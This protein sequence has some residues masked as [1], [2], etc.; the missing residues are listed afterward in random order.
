MGGRVTLV[1][2]SNVKASMSQARRKKRAY[3]LGRLVPRPHRHP[4]VQAQHVDGR[5]TPRVD[6]PPDGRQ[7]GEVAFESPGRARGLRCGVRL[8]LRTARHVHLVAAR[9]QL[10]CGVQPD[11]RVGPGND[12]GLLVGC[13]RESVVITSCL[14]RIGP[15]CMIDSDKIRLQPNL[16]HHRSRCRRWKIEGYV[17]PWA[18][19]PPRPPQAPSRSSA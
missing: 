6:E 15:E 18:S 1:G 16:N 19:P 3:S 5:A 10:R 2:R 13:M 11:P 14:S 9:R 7:R 8:R 17:L 12:D 4:G